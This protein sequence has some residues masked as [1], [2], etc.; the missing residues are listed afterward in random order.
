LFNRAR[1]LQERAEGWLA[2]PPNPQPLTII[3]SYRLI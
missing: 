1:E 2:E 3:G